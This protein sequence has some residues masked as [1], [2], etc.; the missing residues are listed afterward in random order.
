MSD[1]KIQGVSKQ[2]AGVTALNDV[3]MNVSRGERRAL[4][5]PNGA[6]K[7]TLF[8]LITGYLSPTRGEIF[9]ALGTFIAYRR[10]V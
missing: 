10:T 3:T 2:F 5:G 8:H 7:S 1:L 6:G 9:C 4:I